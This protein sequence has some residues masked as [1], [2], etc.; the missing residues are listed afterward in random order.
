MLLMSGAAYAAGGVGGKGDTGGKGGNGP[1]SSAGAGGALSGGS[2]AGLSAGNASQNP[3]FAANNEVERKKKWE[4]GGTWETHRLIRQEDLNNASS[5]LFNVLGVYARYDITANDRIGIRDYFYERFM[6]DQGETGLRTDDVTAT[7]TRTQPLPKDFTFAGTFAI[8]AP[9]SFS[10]QKMGLIT[11]PAL[12]LQIDKKIGKYIGVSARTLGTAYI[13]KYTAAEGGNANPKFRLGGTLEAEVAM[14]FH[15]A[16][17][18]GADVTTGYY[19]YYNV[20]SSTPAG[21]GAVGDA[22][23]PNQPIQQ[24][25]GGEIFARYTLPQVIGI[26]SDITL[27][28]AQGDPS[29]GYTSVLHDGVGHTYGFYRQ[30]SE[31]YA[32]LTLRY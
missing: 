3:D 11:A 17:S 30:S 27:A 13:T 32:A 2:N 5:K 6:A 7:Y 1:G 21:T 4:V 22:T 10:S 19:W 28:F 15:E 9:T 12:I 16:L 23:Y 29:L 14:P 20:Q 8:S 18:F 25:Y 24:T 31:V 26:K